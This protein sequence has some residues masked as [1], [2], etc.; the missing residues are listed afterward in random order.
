MSKLYYFLFSCALLFLPT[1]LLQSQCMA[2]AGTI[3]VNDDGGGTVPFVVCFGDAIDVTSDDNY[4]LPP[5]GPLPAMVYLFY[6]CPPTGPDPQSD[7]CWTSWFWTGEDIQTTNDGGIVGAVGINTF[8]LVPA[9]IDNNQAPPNG[10]GIDVD[11]DMCFDINPDDTETFTF[12]N[13]IIITEVDVDDCAGEVTIQITGGYP[14]FFGGM[15]TVT[16]TGSGIINQSGPDGGTIT[17]TGLMDG[18]SYGFSLDDDGNGCSAS[19]SGGPIDQNIVPPLLEYPDACEGGSVL[20]SIAS[21]GGGDF[22]FVVPPGDG[23]SIDPSTGEVFDVMG[24]YEISYTVFDGCAP[25]TTTFVLTVLPLPPPPDVQGLYEFCADENAFVTPGGIGDFYSL[26]QDEFG[27]DLLETGTSFDMSAYLNPGDPETDF[28]VTQTVGDC[29]SEPSLFSVI[30]YGDSPPLVDPFFDVCDGE[31]VTIEPISGNDNPNSDFFFYSDPFLN[32]LI[33]VGSSYTFTP[34]MTTTIYITELNEFCES[35]PEPVTVFVEFPPTAT[36]GDPMCYAGNTLYSIVL[37]TDAADVIPS[38]GTAIDNGDGTFTI[39]DIPSGAPSVSVLLENAAGDCNAQIDLPFFDCG[40]AAPPPPVSDGD[41]TICV[42]DAIPALSATV[43]AGQEIDWYDAPTNGTL[44]ATGNTYTPTMAGTYYAETRITADGCVSTTRTAITLTVNPVPVLSS[45]MATCAP[46]LLSYTVELV[47]TDADNIMVNAGTVTNNGGGSFTISSIPVGTDFTY[48]AIGVDPNCTL[49]PE[50]ITSPACP[51]PMIN[52]PTATTSQMICPG[53]PIPALTVMV[54]MGLTADWYDAASGGLLLAG[55][56]LSFT[57]P[58]TGT[59]YVEARDPVNNCVSSRIAISLSNHPAPSYNLLGTSCAADLLSYSVQ[60]MLNNADQLMV[61]AGMVTDNGGGSFTVSGIPAGTNLD[62]TISNMATTCSLMDMVTAPDCN[63]AVVMAPMSNGDRTICAGDPIPALSVN[64]NPGETVDWYDAPVGGTQLAT[65]SNTYTPT[66][67]GTYYAETRVLVDGCVSPMRTAVTLTINPLPALVST[68]TLCSADLLT[69]TVTLT[70]TDAASVTANAGTVTDLGG[71]VFEV[72][73]IPTGTPLTFNAFNA[74]MSCELGNTMVASPQCPCPAVAA[75]MPMPVNDICPGDAIPTLEVSVEAGLTADWYDDPVAGALL[76]S[77]TLTYTPPSDGTYYV[78]ARDPVNNCVSERLAMTIITNPNP[79]YVV[80]TAVCAADL[81]SYSVDLQVSNGDQLMVNA[82]TVTDNG[83]GNFVVDGIPAGT[84]LMISLSNSTTGCSIND[85]ITSPDCA[86]GTV[87]PPMSGGDESICTGTPIPAL[88]ADPGPGAIVDWYDAPSGGT[89][90]FTGNSFT[91][92]AAGTYYAETRVIVDD[93]VSF[94]RTPVSL[95]INPTPSIDDIQAAC[96]PNLLTYTVSVSTTDGA[97]ISADFGTVVNNGGGN[98]SITDIPAG[99]D[100]TFTV[101]NSNMSCS[102]GPETV[103]A[104][105]CSC[106]VITDPVSGGDRAICAG[107]PIPSL[108]VMVGAN[109]TADWYDAPMGGTLLAQNSLTYT[110]AA[111]GTYYTEARNTINNCVSNRIALSLTV[112]PIPSFVLMDTICAP[113]LLTYE[114]IIQASDADQLSASL[115]TV[116]DNG[117]GSFTV[118]GIPSGL[119]LNFT[120]SN[121]ATGCELNASTPAPDCS[122]DPVPAPIS[123]GNEAICAGDPIPTLMASVLAGQTVDWY[124]SA[125]GGTLLAANTTTFTP[126]MAGTYFA[127][128]RVLVN[129]CVSDERTPITIIVNPQPQ[130]VD[131]SGSCAPDL[132]TYTATLIFTDA[133]SI[134]VNAGVITNNGDGS[135][136]VNGIPAGTD[137]EYTAANLGMTCELGPLTLMAPD[138]SCPMISPPLSDGDLSYCEGDAIPALSVTLQAGQTADWYD[139][140]NAGSLLQ[141]GSTTY[142]PASVGTYYVEA[143][144]LVNNCVSERIEISVS[145]NSVAPAVSLGDQSVC[146]GETLPALVAQAQPNE[147]IDW[148]DVPSGGTPIATGNGSYTPTAAGTYYAEVRSLLNGC[149]SLSRTP[150][151]LTVFGNPVLEVAN[152]MDPGCNDNGSVTLSTSGGQMP[153]RYQRDGGD[154][155]DDPTF[156]GLGVGNYTFATVDDNGCGDSLDQE[157]FAPAE[158]NASIVDDGVIDCNNDSVELDGS[159]SSQGTDIVYS[160]VGPDNQPLPSLGLNATAEQA[161]QYTLLVTDTITT[162]T[163]QAQITVMDNLTP[164]G[165][166][167]GAGDLI[168]CEDETATLSASSPTTD[169]LSYFW[170]AIEDGNIASDPNQANITVDAGGLYEVLIT[171]LEN[172]CSQTDT[173]RVDEVINTEI[174]LLVTSEDP[175]CAGDSN[176]SIILKPA[177][178]NSTL[179]YAQE[180]EA[181]SLNNSFFNLAAGNYNFVVQDEF[182][183]EVTTSVSLQDGTDLMVNLGPDIFIKLGDSVTFNPIPNVNIGTIVDVNWTNSQWLNCDTCLNAST[184]STLANTA[185]FR[186]TIKDSLGCAASDDIRVFVNRERGVFI[187]SAFSP[188]DDGSNDRLFVQG[189]TDI[190][191]VESFRVFNRWGELVFERLDIPPNAP[192]TGWDGTARAGELLNA[193]VFVYMVEVRFVDGETELFSGDVVLLR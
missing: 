11:G 172:G 178:P 109:E 185:D 10:P 146:E 134:T 6:S 65:N 186:L 69:Y 40:C 43:A 190:E 108:S 145:E 191:R 131:A 103:I 38:V 29:E 179:L 61:N 175:S 174:D 90:L 112:N 58:S 184:L 128:A 1:S 56:T 182:G 105:D 157:L 130:L 170:Q 104:P 86:C 96:A 82:G 76:A 5:S 183:C 81:L 79:T 135:F 84:D 22:D 48:T 85:Q 92:P 46:D 88:T 113:D 53:D 164:P 129:D 125:V 33:T 150:V 28:Y 151:T 62:F 70:L 132:L 168:T 154:L 2:E 34:T 176:G 166:E 23:A 54:D 36:L 144:D 89:L 68:D 192:D 9:V 106:P 122:C 99:N 148:Y 169:P 20:P 167:A 107:D 16:N 180:G 83:G 7:P 147:V 102:A 142:T 155:Q 21:P 60:L 161:G 188:D 126:M 39:Q 49:G 51:C 100:L 31:S 4:V 59:Y 141:S 158:L 118:S 163:A 171:N 55:N 52:A 149:T 24:N 71:G 177:D 121:S 162:C 17:I 153:Y 73:G 8:I 189:G 159:S 13:E 124:D 37:T 30:I 119:A 26:Y 57:P 50:T 42:G 77:S 98:F 95:T 44:L 67:A 123:G 74:D 136:T 181:F 120:L 156:T 139:A 127:E 19:F 47:I 116:T 133:A 140:P 32:D 93:C 160:W 25:A 3:T 193:A 78:E 137:L 15:Y 111:A 72:S 66:M 75:P 91:P 110:P 101:F 63:C 138:C 64:V 115:G 41:Q 143:R 27:N 152:L 80:N 173:V 18:D 165:A 94:A 35:V 97:S 187:P 45:S 117:G 14:E 114:A 12:L 87:N